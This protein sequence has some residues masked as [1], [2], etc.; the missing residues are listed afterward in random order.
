MFRASLCP[1]SGYQ[2]VCYCT[3]WAALVLLDVV[4][5]GCGAL[6]CRVRALWRLLFDWRLQTCWQS[7]DNKH[8]TVESCWFSLSLH[9]LVEIFVVSPNF[10][11]R[12]FKMATIIPLFI[13]HVN[14][15]FDVKGEGTV[16]SETLHSARSTSIR[17][18]VKLTVYIFSMWLCFNISLLL[19][20][21]TVPSLQSE[22]ICSYNTNKFK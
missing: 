11:A 7:V 5:R 21:T 3:W 20:L 2:D 18:K 17:G 19:I 14:C 22:E 13:L 9:D 6:R 1:S 15:E 4:G 10:Q 8:L 16:Q 12:W